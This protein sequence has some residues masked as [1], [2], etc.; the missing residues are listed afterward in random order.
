MKLKILFT[1]DNSGSINGNA[2]YFNEISRIIHKYYK[3]G[4]KFYLW[5]NNYTEKSKSEIDEWIQQRKGSGGTNSENIAYIAKACPT[6]REH[7]IIVTDGEVSEKYIKQC[8]VLM[9]QYNI[10]FKFVSVYVIGSGGNLSVGAPFCRGCPNR[11]IHV[12]NANERINGPSLSLD[13]IAASK[14]IPFISTILEFDSIYD[15]IYSYIKAIQLGKNENT[16]LKNQLLSLKS[17]IIGNLS[18]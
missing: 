4:D 7:L 6:H 13:E 10:K 5:E 14:R 18:N 3:N 8:D 11:T 2:V 1:F 16:D 9:N 12:L 15:K 17:R